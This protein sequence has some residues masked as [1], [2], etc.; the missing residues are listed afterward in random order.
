MSLARRP[1]WHRRA[2]ILRNVLNPTSMRL[3]MILAIP[4]QWM[5]FQLWQ[6]SRERSGT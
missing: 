2:T 4:S 1:S 5:E 3:L 6:M